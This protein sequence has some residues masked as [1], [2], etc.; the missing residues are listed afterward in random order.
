MNSAITLLICVLMLTDGMQQQM[1]GAAQTQRQYGAEKV[2]KCDF[3]GCLS[4]FVTRS[5]LSFHQ[6]DHLLEKPL[7]SFSRRASHSLRGAKRGREEVFG[8]EVDKASNRIAILAAVAEIVLPPLVQPQPTISSQVLVAKG[9]ATTVSFYRQA[10]GDHDGSLDVDAMA[11]DAVSPAIEYTEG[12]EDQNFMDDLIPLSSPVISLAGDDTSEVVSDRRT[13]ESEMEDSPEA[14]LPKITNEPGSQSLRR[15][16][17]QR[18]TAL[19]QP[20]ADPTFPV[21]PPINISW[22]TLSRQTSGQHSVDAVDY[23][24]I[25]AEEFEAL[26]SL[27]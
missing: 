3:E 10:D 6:C 11:Y 16:I 12:V 8:G 18:C 2:F 15:P 17:A 13:T 22:F 20:M 24:D 27:M 9:Q 14:V 5:G 26:V 7:E 4:S 21:V 25:T 19:I 1:Y 23:L